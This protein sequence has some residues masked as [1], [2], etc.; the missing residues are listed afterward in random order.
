M[1][2]AIVALC[3]DNNIPLPTS[4]DIH[5]D[6]EI[7]SFVHVFPDG[8]V[9]NCLFHLGQAIY[10]KVKKHGLTKRY[11]EDSEFR[12]AVRMLVALAF[13]PVAEV[14]PYFLHLRRTIGDNPL[15]D[16]FDHTYVRGK[17]LR[18]NRGVEV[19]A[20]PR[21]PIENW[22]VHDRLENEIDRTNN[23]IE[24]FNKQLK[25]CSARSHLGLHEL[26]Q[27]LMNMNSK[28]LHSIRDH[29]AR[30]A[31]MPKKLRKDREREN[32]L[33][34]LVRLFDNEEIDGLDFLYGIQR[35]ISMN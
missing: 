34:N 16:Y 3:E 19:R 4:P 8:Q 10:R 14:T 27:L 32:A 24:S 7:N 25:I 11:H 33:H 13:L 31:T 15:V 22:N 21:F 23:V 12:T 9:F 20:P 18:I 2:S 17:L 29:L 28:M 30:G 26:V 1:W 6:F 5:L 35:N